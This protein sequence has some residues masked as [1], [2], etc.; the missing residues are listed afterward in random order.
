[1]PRWFELKRRHCDEKQDYYIIQRKSLI[2]FHF[3]KIQLRQQNDQNMSVFLRTNGAF[4]QST[5]LTECAADVT[6]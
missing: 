6:Q 1:M 4:I 3:N 2:M 5:E